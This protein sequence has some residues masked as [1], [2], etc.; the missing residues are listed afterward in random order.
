MTQ[1]LTS[2][3]KYR[4]DID[5]LRAIAILS[6]IAFH[7][8]PKYFPGGFIGVDVFFVLSGFLITSLIQAQL[9]D[10][11]F[12]ILDFY[13]RRIRRIFPA[14][15]TVLIFSFALGCFTLSDKE[16]KS[17]SASMIGSATF[18]QNYVLAN[19]LGYFD[20]EAT[21]K[22]LLHI[23]SLGI[24]E[25]FYIFWPAIL[26]IAYRKNMGFK[27][28]FLCLFLSSF[29]YSQFL[30][31]GDVTFAFYSPLSRSWELIAGS[32]LALLNTKRTT[33]STAQPHLVN[34]WRGVFGANLKS[35]IGASLILLA[36]FRLSP[37]LNYPGL[38][39]FLPIVG[40]MLILSSKD[41]WINRIALSNRLMVFIGLISYPLYLWH[42]PLMA[43]ARIHFTDSLPGKY[44]LPIIA[45]STL[46]AWAT[47]KFIENPFRFKITSTKS[48]IALISGMLITLMLGL[49]GY[50]TNGFPQR[51][52]D[53]LRPFIL[54]GEETSAHWRRGECLLLPEQNYTNFIK[55]CD[56]GPSK[57]PL[58]LIWGDSYA[59]AQYPGLLALGS[60]S[61][62]KVAEYTSSACPPLL[63]FEHPQREFCMGNNDFVIEKIKELKPK[64]VILH[65]TWQYNQLDLEMGLKHS[66]AQIRKTGSSKIILLGP[67]PMWRAGGLSSN[68]MDYYFFHGFKLLPTRT[69]YRLREDS[70][71]QIMRNISSQLGVQY[72]SAK[73]VLCNKDG[74]LARIGENNSKLTAFD[75]GHMTVEGSTYLIESIQLQIFENLP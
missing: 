54:S 17:L 38:Y 7:A 44:M 21:R 48:L 15:I 51:I 40:A 75:A 6:V 58:V 2:P 43:F 50:L 64:I 71:E 70:S 72:I 4:S 60:R 3:I 69:T 12:S 52:P 36:I 33:D 31:H 46:F 55:S 27:T 18:L 10:N 13:S 32:S 61:G 74:C 9:K 67:V 11:N 35:V 68:V 19:E 16:F 66:V 56:G 29:A 22:P 14:L 62:F 73:E 34:F 1:N 47:Y 23:W 45:I 42:Y 63:G 20:V 28:I 8:F 25:Q 59:A 65:S 53:E 37:Q 26:L 39:A 49:F 57:A 41:S 30:T 24:E 5:G